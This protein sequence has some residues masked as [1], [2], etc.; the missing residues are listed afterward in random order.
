V[1]RREPE[2]DTEQIDLLLALEALKR[3]LGP[4]GELMSEATSEDANPNNYDSPLRYVAA[5][6]FTNW[7]EKA[8]Q[9]AID[10]W[11]KSAGENPNTNGHY[12][13]VEKAD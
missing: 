12:W 1:T 3:D 13:T 4:N 7:A 5:G 11:K 8:K 6:P 2:W 10:S 9:D